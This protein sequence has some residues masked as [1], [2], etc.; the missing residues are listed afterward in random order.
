MVAP[1][2]QQDPS[3]YALR[4]ALEE[5]CL[6]VLNPLE[7][8]PLVLKVPEDVGQLFIRGVEGQLGERREECVGGVDQHGQGGVQTR[9]LSSQRQQ[10]RDGRCISGRQ[11]EG[12]SL[13]FLWNQRWG[14]IGEKSDL[15]PQ[16]T[17]PRHRQQGRGQRIIVIIIYYIFLDILMVVSEKCTN[18]QHQK[19]HLSLSLTPTPTPDL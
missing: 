10:R 13:L 16:G 9:G 5:E 3:V 4:Y 6:A 18:F 17:W 8:H 11:R 14:L 7:N 12:A 19:E 15:V 2:R 1:L